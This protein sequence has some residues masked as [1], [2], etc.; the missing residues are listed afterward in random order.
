MGKCG[1]VFQSM[2]ESFWLQK[3]S[4]ITFFIYFRVFFFLLPERKLVL[5]ISMEHTL[6]YEGNSITASLLIMCFLR[7][8]NSS[9]PY[10]RGQETRRILS[11]LSAF[12]IVF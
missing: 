12:Y 5:T 10:S 11:L 6:S 8:T 9:L 2:K 3:I 7:K 1:T 4:R